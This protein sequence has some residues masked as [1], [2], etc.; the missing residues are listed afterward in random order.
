MAEGVGAAVGA[1]VYNVV[2]TAQMGKSAVAEGAQIAKEGVNHI[3][4]STRDGL[5][6]AEQEAEELALAAG[7][8]VA[9]A[10]HRVEEGLEDAV[11]GVAKL[12][13]ATRD[14]FKKTA[15][16][17]DRKAHELVEE[18]HQDVQAVGRGFQSA[19]HRVEE[20]AH[21]IKE[22]GERIR[23]AARRGYENPEEAR[24]RRRNRREHDYNS[25]ESMDRMETRGDT[26]ERSTTLPPGYFQSQGQSS[27]SD[28][29][30]PP[31][32]QGGP[33]SSGS[34]RPPSPRRQHGATSS[35]ASQGPA[36]S[37]TAPA[38][39]S[40]LQRVRVTIVGAKGLHGTAEGDERGTYCVC[41]VPGQKSSRLKTEVATAPNPLW[42]EPV[43]L[44][45][46]PSDELQL[47]VFEKDVWPRSDVLLGRTMLPLADLLDCGGF[48]GELQLDDAGDDYGAC[49]QVCAK[50]LGPAPKHEQGVS[51]S[52]AAPSSLAAPLSSVTSPATSATFSRGGIS[53]SRALARSA[54]A[55]SLHSPTVGRTAAP[56]AAQGPH[57]SRRLK[58]SISS[59]RS[60][61]APS[62][63]SAAVRDHLQCICS[64]VGRPIT[65]VQTRPCGSIAGEV[66]WNS[67]HE[68]SEY[69]LG[70]NLEF[71][72]VDSMAQASPSLAN[73][74]SPS[75]PLS[76]ALRH[77]I[78]GTCLLSAE[79]FIRFGFDSELTL[80]SQG[81][82]ICGL[83]R[84]KV[85]V[86]DPA[87]AGTVPAAATGSV[88]LHG[89][90][91]I[92]PSASAS[93]P[94]P[95]SP[96]GSLAS[97]GIPHHS[98]TPISPS[99]RVGA[100]PVVH[101]ATS[102]S[103]TGSVAIPFAGSVSAP[104]AGLPRSP[105][106]GLPPAAMGVPAAGLPSTSFPGVPQHLT[107]LSP[108]G[109]SP[110]QG[111]PSPSAGLAWGR[112][113]MMGGSR[114]VPALGRES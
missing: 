29:R 106:G 98:A 84:V 35:M 85:S 109:L 100:T 42:N 105:M 67:D 55:P 65:S 1:G 20:G 44:D 68:I 37:L 26:L 40:N 7:R 70:E 12:G 74:V 82:G 73:G 38:S 101:Q 16:A 60:F 41:E 61:A 72:V 104:V 75:S 78:V 19:V 53:A 15:Q 92:S 14:F 21:H 102:I 62:I 90:A 3:A 107:P 23:E 18:V 30:A 36:S 114:W 69:H 51:V 81:Q 24:E 13:G 45:C 9:V 87:F 56:V 99:Y 97:V 95:V 8:G 93:F 28:R 32:S 108:Q 48:N 89:F 71:A 54:A 2:K 31:R 49:V 34:P 76:S 43:E 64:V 39:P 11:H 86:V 25:M 83:L 112:R 111:V 22:S 80:C 33:S 27:S 79:Q 57:A 4:S 66:V 110:M 63:A 88:P 10:A 58:I 52:T 103:P 46:E 96:T 77:G 91:P 47:S 94:L 5:A 6:R 113:H 17:V 50:V 59:F